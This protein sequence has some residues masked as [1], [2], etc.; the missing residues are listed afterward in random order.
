MTG[1]MHR[2]TRW[3]DADAILVRSAVMHDM[4]FSDKLCVIG[5]AGAGVNNIPLGK[6]SE[7][8]IAVFNTPGANAN[9]VK[10]LV[11]A[12]MLLAARDIVGGMYWVRSERQNEDLEKMAEKEK[13]RFAG[14]E[15]L[16]QK[17]GCDRSGS[18]RYSGGKRSS[19]SWYGSVWI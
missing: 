7:Q 18:N 19:S 13:K 4:E 9:G 8:G 10:E 5:R 14:T 16:W 15:L 2:Q 17:A 3:R 6:C 1:I 12:G 11:I